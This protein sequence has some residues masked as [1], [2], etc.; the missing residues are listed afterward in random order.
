MN[1]DRRL[2]YSTEF[3]SLGKP[4]GGDKKKK[5]KSQPPQAPAIKNPA[6][7]GVRIRRESKGR[8]GKNVCV[9]DGLALSDD[10]LREL[11]KKLK[12]QLGT[13]GAV[14][15]G[16]IEIQGDHRDKLLMLLDKEGIKAKL[17]GG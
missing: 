1:D 3:G 14:K 13:G 7:Q 10:K 12:N 6:K 15:D 16:C 4:M 2:V 5:G 11:L 17:A 9:I 8:G